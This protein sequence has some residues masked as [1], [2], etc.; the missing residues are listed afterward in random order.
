MNTLMLTEICTGHWYRGVFLT[1]YD[2]S[3]PH[4]QHQKNIEIEASSSIKILAA[5]FSD[6]VNLS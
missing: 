5:S 4:A 6:P 2:F 1:A 3:S